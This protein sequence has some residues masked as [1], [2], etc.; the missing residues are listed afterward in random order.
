MAQ[1]EKSEEE[2]GEKRKR[3]EEKEENR[4]ETVKRK[5]EGCVSVEA[6]EIFSQEG[7][8]ESCGDLSW[9]DLLE[10]SA[11]TCLIVSLTLVRMC[12]WCLM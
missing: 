9:V 12:V 11:R 8:L 10:R 1:A 4:T 2:K 6:C 5:C 7:D 3:E